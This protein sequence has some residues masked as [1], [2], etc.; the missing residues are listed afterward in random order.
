M[1]AHASAACALTWSRG[2]HCS[3]ALPQPAD[4]PR[5]GA[6][7]APAAQR[8]LCTS[9]WGVTPRGGGRRTTR[10]VG[11]NAGAGDAQ[12]TLAV[13][14]APA[15]KEAAAAGHSRNGNGAVMPTSRQQVRVC[16]LEGRVF[17]AL[18][19]QLQCAGV[20]TR[21]GQLDCLHPSQAPAP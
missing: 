5:L 21:A 13:S 11:V 15:Q 1:H 6:G 12:P 19:S 17:E 2:A 7:G 10:R 8:A 14:A 18:C 16:P 3:P 9:S 20:C 4:T